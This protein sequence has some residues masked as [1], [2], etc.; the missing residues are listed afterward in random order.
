MD[1]ELIVR[2]SRLTKGPLL[3]R[4]NEI[5]KDFVKAGLSQY[6]PND[7]FSLKSLKDGIKTIANVNL[8]DEV[9]I[10]ILEDLSHEGSVNHISDLEYI[11]NKKIDIP[12]FEDLTHDV[13]NEFEGFLKKE[14][15]DYDP[16]IDAIVKDVFNSVLLILSVNIVQSQRTQIDSLPIENLRAII[17]EEAHEENIK[18]R[19]KFVDIFCEY[20]LSKSPKLLGFIFERYSGIINMDLILKE[21][22]M[23]CLNL[24][25]N[26]GFLLVD[27]TFLVALMCKTDPTYSLALAVSTQSKKRSLPSI[28]Y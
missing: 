11:I 12:Q 16:Y 27:T 6:N 8:E 20:I 15:A 28:L 18:W 17:E 3:E 22:D 9:V 13:W 5:N 21:R 26:I 24:I 23:P 10:S 14:Y 2:L 1:S 7:S 19:N 25:D 4:R